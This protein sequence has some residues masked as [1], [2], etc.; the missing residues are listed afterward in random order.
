[1]IDCFTEESIKVIMLA[2]DESRRLGHSFVST[3]QILLGAIGEG[4]SVAAEILKSKGVTLERARIEVERISGRGSYLI[5]LE[6][7]FLPEA[8][9]SFNL[10]SEE[11]ERLN[12]NYIDVDHLMIEVDHLM[13]GMLRVEDGIGLQVLTALGVEANEVLDPITRSLSDNSSPRA[14]RNHARALENRAMIELGLE[15]VERLKHDRPD[16]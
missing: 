15:Q 5:T 8:H 13:L 1:M 16:A 3:G 14:R 2:Q 4:T 11:S 10:A 12:H 6:I 9:R 7:P